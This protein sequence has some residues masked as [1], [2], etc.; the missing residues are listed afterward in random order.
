VVQGDTKVKLGAWEVKIRVQGMKGYGLNRC[1]GS[2]RTKVKKGNMKIKGDKGSKGN[3]HIQEGMRE[4]SRRHGDQEKS[5]RSQEDMGMSEDVREG[6]RIE[7]N[8][9]QRSRKENKEEK[10][11][12]GKVPHVV[13]SLWGIPRRVPRALVI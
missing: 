5:K 6:P 4:C 7:G 10:H 8:K 2:A 1:C 12:R 13:V 11:T 9:R 3:G